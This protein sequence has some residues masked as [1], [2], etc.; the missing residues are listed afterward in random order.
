VSA[1]TARGGRRRGGE[2]GA[3]ADERWLLTYSDMITLLMALFIVMWSISSVNIS[4]FDQLKAS[5][6]SAF[7]GKVLPDNNSILSGQ[8]APFDQD[9]TP[10][11]MIN[12]A[13]QQPIF[14]MKS[15]SASITQA[16][17]QQDSENLK[18][19][20]Q[21]VERYA[22]QHG[23]ANE[24][25]TTIN[26]RGLVVRLLTDKVLFSSGSAVLQPQGLPLLTEISHLLTRADI[27]NPVRVEG[28]TDDVPIHSAVYPS[29]WELSTARADAVLE[30][31]L[32]AKV[33]PKRLSVAGYGEQNPIASNETAEGRSENRRVDLVILR[34]SFNKSS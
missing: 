22:Q 27:V 34:R 30:F 31:L 5:L 4:K 23:F 18:H 25:H 9:G 29:N 11:Q 12:P 19:I 14:S 2:E 33:S 32:G 24:V 7:S 6:K 3:H 1:A 8:T 16:A 17:A 15:I 10:V 26:E 21:Q 20:Q 13:V 28:N